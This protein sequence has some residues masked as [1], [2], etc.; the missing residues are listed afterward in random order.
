MG[1]MGH[2]TKRRRRRPLSGGVD[3]PDGELSR[4]QKTEIEMGLTS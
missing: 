3:L 2:R 1:Q 4:L